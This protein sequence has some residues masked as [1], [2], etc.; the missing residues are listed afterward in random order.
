[1]DKPKSL[2]IP[3]LFIFLLLQLTILSGTAQA[4]KGKKIDAMLAG[5]KPQVLVG[6]STE[7]KAFGKN[8][9]LQSVEINPSDGISVRDIKETTP[10]PNNRRQQEKG[11]KVWSFTILVEKTAQSG[12]RS[13]VLVTPEGHSEQEII[14][15]VTHIPIITG[16]EILSTESSSCKIEFT[17]SVF[18]EAGDLG[19]KPDITVWVECGGAGFGSIK[20]AKSVVKKDAI[21]STVHVVISNVTPGS[22]CTGMCNLRVSI[23][24]ATGCESDYLKTQVEFKR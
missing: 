8:L 19:A 4:Q 11:T 15:I 16:I 1:M 20:A 18:D 22:Y 5:Y 13:V 6:Q 12:E 3:C 23:E 17:L 9:I 7:L 24:G 2:S 21:N 14:R 10:D